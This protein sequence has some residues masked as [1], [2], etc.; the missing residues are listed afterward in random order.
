MSILLF[1]CLLWT[2]VSIR[3]LYMEFI[4]AL[5]KNFGHWY[6]FFYIVLCILWSIF[7]YLA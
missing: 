6:W 2:I 7:Y 1:F 5:P 4:H 3:I